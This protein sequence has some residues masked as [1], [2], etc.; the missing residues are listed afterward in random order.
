MKI[1]WYM[2]KPKQNDDISMNNKGSNDVPP[3]ILNTWQSTPK[4]DSIVDN[5]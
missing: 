1:L 4:Y 2:Q 3:I 5:R